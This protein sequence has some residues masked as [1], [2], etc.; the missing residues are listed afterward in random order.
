MIERR[1]PQGRTLSPSITSSSD[2]RSTSGRNGCQTEAIDASLVSQ[3]HH[4]KVELIRQ[5]ND[6]C[7]WRPLSYLLDDLTQATGVLIDF[8]DDQGK[9]R[10]EIPE[11]S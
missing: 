7:L 10:R 4:L 2:L 5:S 3:P 9:L 6:P 11:P 1:T 8:D